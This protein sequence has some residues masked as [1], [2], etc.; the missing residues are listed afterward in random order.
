MI[1]TWRCLFEECCDVSEIIERSK[2]PSKTGQGSHKLPGNFGGERFSAIWLGHSS[3][4]D[5]LDSIQPIRTHLGQSWPR[6]FFS[7]TFSGSPLSCS[8]VKKKQPDAKSGIFTIDP[9]GEGGEKHFKVF[10]D[11]RDKSGVG[12]TVISHDSLKR[13]RVGGCEEPGCFAHAV[14]YESTPAQTAGLVAVSTHCAQH[15]KYECHSAML[16]LD[17]G[18]SW[19]ESRDGAR[20]KYWGGAPPGSN[21]CACGMANKCVQPEQAC[22]CDENDF[23]WREDSGLLTYKPDLPVS[24]LRFGEISYGR[25]DAFFTL[26]E[27]KCYTMDACVGKKCL[28]GGTCKAVGKDGYAC[29]CSGGFRGKHCESGGYGPMKRALRFKPPIR[30]VVSP[31]Y[32]NDL[33]NQ[34]LK[35]IFIQELVAHWCVNSVIKPALTMWSSS[36][37]F[38]PRNRRMQREVSLRQECSMQEHHGILRL[39]LR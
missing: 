8:D 30:G 10:C 18:N 14:T 4:R 20:M 36:F 25:E 7:F 9:D 33:P 37:F 24:K 12:V 3:S 39:F 31:C 1:E 22:N 21:K 29:S 32:G 38:F 27:L 13:T 2:I 23:K 28:N 16:Q 17:R 6:L 26:G 15:I 19:L 35:V 5:S 34:E 11:M